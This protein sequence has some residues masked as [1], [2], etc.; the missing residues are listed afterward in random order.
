M[1]RIRQRPLSAGVKVGPVIT[2]S[3]KVNP[4]RMTELITH[5]V[6]VSIAGRSKCY[7]SY[8]F[9]KGDAAIHNNV[10][11]IFAH[12]VVHL[13]V[14]QSEDNSFISD[15]SLVMT[16]CI[17]D[18]LFVC[19]LIGQL[20]IDLS[21]TPVPIR[22]LFNPFDPVVTNAH[23]HP[24]IKPDT[25]VFQRSCKARHSRH[26]FSYCEGIGLQL[27]NKYIRKTEIG[28]RIFI[29]SSVKIV[30]VA[31]K[32]ALQTVIK[33]EHTRHPVKSEPIQMVLFH[34]ILTV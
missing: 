25:S 22:Q 3:R 32:I 2:F 30:I 14:Y 28:Y 16:L 10:L 26:I 7:E 4:F 6:E 12:R 29:L 19:T 31:V 20:I 21:H 34:P 9:M 17:T 1:V 23:T 27:F 13:L 15:K 18:S 8:H 5:E 33:I 24:E 11:R